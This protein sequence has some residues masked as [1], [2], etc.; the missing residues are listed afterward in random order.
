[1]TSVR[2]TLLQ[3]TNASGFGWFGPNIINYTGIVNGYPFTVAAGAAFSVPLVLENFDNR[4]HT[5]YSVTAG[6]PFTFTS[7]TPTLP[8]SLLAL[9][10]S[11]VLQLG[12]IAP[13]NPG[14]SL[15]LFVTVNALPP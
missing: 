9:E 1:V 3:G 15:T 12:F 11:A 8:A 5:I 14:A 4:T 2:F 7:S 6:T 13:S 10:D